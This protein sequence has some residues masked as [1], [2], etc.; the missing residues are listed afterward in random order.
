MLHNALSLELGYEEFGDLI[1][2]EASLMLNEE[3]VSTSSI[4]RPMWYVKGQ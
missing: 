1:I 3:I 4:L 2:V